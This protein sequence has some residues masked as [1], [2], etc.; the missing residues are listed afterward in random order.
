MRWRPWRVPHEPLH[1]DVPCAGCRAREC[2]VPGHPCIDDV[3]VDTVLSKS[4]DSFDSIQNSF[5]SIQPP[6]SSD[7]DRTRS[8]LDDLLLAAS[9]DLSQL[10]IDSRRQD[11][12]S[13]AKALTS[14]TS[15][16]AKL[17]AFITERTS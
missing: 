17:N 13:L 14:L 5:D 2:P 9:D 3:D 4:E 6:K 16:A 11:A 7:A 10:R 12:S 15:D 1:A 8:R